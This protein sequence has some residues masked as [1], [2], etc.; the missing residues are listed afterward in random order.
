MDWTLNELNNPSLLDGPPD[1][2][3]R[4][5]RLQDVR[6]VIAYS[7]PAREVLEAIMRPVSHSDIMGEL[8]SAAR[9][10]GNS[11]QQGVGGASFVASPNPVPLG[12]G[13]GSTT[14]SWTTGD[15]QEGR[16][17]V[18]VDGGRPQ[19]FGTGARGSQEAPWIGFG[20]IY[21]F[22]LRSS[23]GNLLATVTVQRRA[24][25]AQQYRV[26]TWPDDKRSP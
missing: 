25:E 14:I 10:T 4:A 24:T 5:L 7:Q 21:E 17:Y 20:G 6:F 15:G 12:A 19:L 16:V 13:M 3:E 11:A 1:S 9:S 8:D 23:R 2:V 26:Y 22:F 18:S